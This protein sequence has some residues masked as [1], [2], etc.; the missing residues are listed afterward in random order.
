MNASSDAGR[1]LIQLILLLL[2]HS[3]AGVE[4]AARPSKENER[5]KE[6]IFI[7]SSA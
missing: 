6:G 3:V 4:A 5:R 1:V 7:A 2:L